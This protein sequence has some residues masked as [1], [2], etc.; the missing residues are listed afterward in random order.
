MPEPARASRPKRV[1]VTPID[2]HQAVRRT[3]RDS[4]HAP[5]RRRPKAINPRRVQPFV[6][7]PQAEPAVVATP[8]AIEEAA[9]AHGQ[10]VA[11]TSGGVD[12]HLFR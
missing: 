9:V 12:D 1:H 11:H 5:E 8:K 2:Q 7:V 3:S 6:L 10:A 4:K